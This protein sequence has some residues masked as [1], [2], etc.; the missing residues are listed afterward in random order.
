MSVYVYAFNI[1]HPGLDN[2]SDMLLF[3][4]SQ[5]ALIFLQFRQLS[6]CFL[7]MRQ[8]LLGRLDAAANGIMQEDT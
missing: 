2:P 7:W 3:L 5:F 8:S 1:L 4:F 6:L